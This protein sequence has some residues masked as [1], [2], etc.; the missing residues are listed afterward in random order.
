M[1]WSY[2]TIGWGPNPVAW[3]HKRPTHIDKTG[4]K[5][6]LAIHQLRSQSP[7]CSLPGKAHDL[8]DGAE[9]TEEKKRNVQGDSWF[10]IQRRSPPPLVCGD[11]PQL[12]ASSSTYRKE[13]GLS[14][15]PLKGKGQSPRSPP[16]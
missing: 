9:K 1:L 15:R 5:N 13:A 6:T 14:E 3:Q 16:N 7:C 10:Q 2:A 8:Q 12:S 11:K 4:S